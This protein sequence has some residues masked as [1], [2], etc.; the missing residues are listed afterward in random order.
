MA[1]VGAGQPAP[2]EYLVSAAMVW[3]I[4]HKGC[5][6][7]LEN[8]TDTTQCSAKSTASLSDQE[9]RIKGEG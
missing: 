2:G 9:R 8:R 1:L 4:G 7:V 5:S 6:W 3:T